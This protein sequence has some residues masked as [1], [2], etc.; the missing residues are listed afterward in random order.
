MAKFIVTV[1]SSKNGRILDAFGMK[2]QGMAFFFQESNGRWINPQFALE[3][4]HR[5]AFTI[6]FDDESVFL[7]S[8]NIVTEETKGK[9]KIITREL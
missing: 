6:L 7:N 8:N 1:K 5:I 2:S 9:Y 4:A 3:D